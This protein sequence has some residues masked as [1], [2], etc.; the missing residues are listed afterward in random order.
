MLPL[1]PYPTAEGLEEIVDEI[2]SNEAYGVHLAAGLIKLWYTELKEPIVPKSAYRDLVTFFDAGQPT[3]EQLHDLLSPHSEWSCLPS[4]S[5]EILSRHLLPLLS[6][7]VKH[8]EQNK[9]TA[10]NLAVVF[11]PTFVCGPDQMEDMKISNMLRP[12][13]TV[14]IENWSQLREVF[15]IDEKTFW[16]D[17]EPPASMDDYEDP[18]YERTI[19]PEKGTTSSSADTIMQSKGIVL[20]GLD[21]PDPKPEDNVEVPRKD[22][23]VP[24]PL[25]PRSVP[26]EASPPIPALPPRI[27]TGPTPAMRPPTSDPSIAKS[28]TADEISNSMSPVRRKPAPPLNVPPPRY[29]EHAHELSDSPTSMAAPVDGFGPARRGDWSLHS[30]DVRDSSIRDSSPASLAGRSGSQ[31]ST[32]RKPVGSGDDTFSY[33]S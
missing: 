16:K 18:L 13:I 5:R 6:E 12:I 3:V 24:P 1:P 32:K 21:I 29:T 22:S 31:A 17:I 15:G 26:Q 2:D 19:T 4:V 7:L 25:P 30:T 11:A 8:Q 28:H 20:Q 33:K 27:L 9:M 14:A 10:E 23:T